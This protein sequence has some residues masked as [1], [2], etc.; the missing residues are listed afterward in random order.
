MPISESEAAI[1]SMLS[2][3]PKQ[4]YLPRTPV[5]FNKEE[6]LELRAQV[7]DELQGFDMKKLKDIYLELT[8]FD[9]HL[10][11]FV[12]FTD[13]GFTLMKFQVFMYQFTKFYYGVT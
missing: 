2:K 13:L 3:L 9:Q 12:S 10:T 6:E 1:H 4:G 5:T 7:W 11:G 8:G